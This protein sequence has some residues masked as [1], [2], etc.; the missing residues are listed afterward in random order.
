VVCSPDS[1][2][3]FLFWPQTTDYGLFI[4]SM[5]FTWTFTPFASLTPVQLY[6]I[7]AARSTVFVVE[8][9]CPYQDMDGVDEHCM[10]LVAW[11]GKDVAAYLRIVPPGIKFAEPSIGRVI[12]ASMFRGTGLG[13]ELMRRGV[14]Q[15]DELYPNRPSRI[16]AQAHLQ[17]FYAGFGYVT[18]SAIYLEDGIPHVE[19]VRTGDGD[20]PSTHSGQS[21]CG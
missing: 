4:Y 10:H 17:K 13:R 6:S 21:A 16:G 8:Q 18:S 9:N 11:H 3:T 14:L 2:V 12:T 20:G 19:M 15:L 1:G 7:L 5:P